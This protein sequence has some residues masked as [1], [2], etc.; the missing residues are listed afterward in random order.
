[1]LTP[2]QQTLRSLLFQHPATC[3][4]LSLDLLDVVTQHLHS[5]K[6]HLRICAAHALVGLAHALRQHPDD[7]Q[8][9]AISVRDLVRCR[10][11]AFV[12]DQLVLYRKALSKN[13]NNPAAASQSL[14]GLIVAQ[15]PQ[16]A[17]ADQG[18]QAGWAFTVLAALIVL[19]DGKVFLSKQFLKFVITTVYYCIPQQYNTLHTLHAGVIRALVWAFTRLEELQPSDPSAS[20]LQNGATRREAAYQVLKDALPGDAGSALV[21]ALLRPAPQSRPAASGRTA[22]VEDF[23]KAMALTEDFL[24]HTFRSY[25][26]QGVTLLCAFTRGLSE[27]ERNKPWDREVLVSKSMMT[28]E[29]V[30]GA[31]KLSP[32]SSYIGTRPFTDV[33]IVK[34]WDAFVRMFKLALFGEMIHYERAPVSAIALDSFQFERHSLNER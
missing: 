13:S 22:E 2:L 18:P 8:E 24:K 5:P 30:E 6:L 29:A 3:F 28:G 20:M 4:P 33:E 26:V 15:I 7:Q 9:S 17:D 16:T 32:E 23:D 1:M 31:G 27:D 25:K 21:Y 12:E 10:V 19:S 34:R 14:P 11:T